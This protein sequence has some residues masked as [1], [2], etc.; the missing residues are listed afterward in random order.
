MATIILLHNQKLAYVL[1]PK[2]ATT[3]MVAMMHAFAG[4]DNLGQAP[5]KQERKKDYARKLVD[6]GVET[7]HLPPAKIV[8]IKQKYPDYFIF[9][10]SRDPTTRIIS[11]YFSKI[12]RYAKQFNKTAYLAGKMGQVMGGIKALQ[13]SRISAKHVTKIISFDQMLDGLLKHG[14]EFDGHFNLQS[15]I[16]NKAETDY[17]MVLK[18]ENLQQDLSRLCTEVGLQNALIDRLGQWNQSLP[19]H[20]N[21]IIMTPQ[22]SDNIW[23]LYQ[24]DFE[25]FDYP[26]P[27]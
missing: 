16:T 17:D 18:I 1:T 13:D 8:E 4:L 24:K 23:Q 11:S 6:H 15:K 25:L 2:V 14:I 27:E 10:I 5:R 12:Q 26:K 9:C 19:E 7:I 3:T 21:K 22:R 20:N